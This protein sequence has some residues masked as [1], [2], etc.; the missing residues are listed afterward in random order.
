MSRCPLGF[1]LIVNAL[2]N[3]SPCQVHCVGRDWRAFP[4]KTGGM[5]LEL[6]FPGRSYQEEEISRL[7]QPF[8]I[9]GE[10]LPP[11]GPGLAAAIARQ[12]GGAL[13]MQPG[14]GGGLRLRLEIPDG[15]GPV[16]DEVR[17]EDSGA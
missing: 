9:R 14:P 4:L 10:T 3:R 13:V 6:S 11:L 2:A 15:K 1:G 7:L 17:G 8:K 12:H 16:T 5:D